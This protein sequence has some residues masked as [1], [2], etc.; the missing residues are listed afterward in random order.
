MVRQISE[1]RYQK[2]LRYERLEKRWNKLVGG[3]TVKDVLSPT[4]KN[5]QEEKKV[6]KGKE[7]AKER[8]DI[9]SE[10]EAVVL[11]AGK[12]EWW[13]VEDWNE[14]PLEARALWCRCEELPDQLIERFGEAV[15]KEEWRQALLLYMSH[16]RRPWL[17]I[18]HLD[19]ATH[20]FSFDQGEI[21]EFI[22]RAKDWI[23]EAEGLLAPE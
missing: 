23:A 22:A 2:L 9:L 11:E 4:Y 19:E 7:K 8:Y 18:E 15:R 3:L 21:A 10:A 13:S 14:L 12:P 5:K 1:K 20:D 6:M 17:P 16:N